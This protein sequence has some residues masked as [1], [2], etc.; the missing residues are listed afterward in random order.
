M[1][2]H[3]HLSTDVSPAGIWTSGSTLQNFRPTFPPLPCES[4][5]VA[6]VRVPSLIHVARLDKHS[7]KRSRPRFAVAEL[8]YLGTVFRSTSYRTYQS[9][10]FLSLPVPSS[11]PLSFGVHWSHLD[12]ACSCTVYD[13][14]RSDVHAPAGSCR[15][16][17]QAS[18]A[19]SPSRDI[20]PGPYLSR[21]SGN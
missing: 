5:S 11:V 10:G 12:R 1:A 4:L 2:G 16:I 17:L 14:F 8:S 7:S 21:I 18:A 9:G 19:R 6:F 20:R 13:S 3:S 15:F